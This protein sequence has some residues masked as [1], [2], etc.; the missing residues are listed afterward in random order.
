[1]QNIGNTVRIGRRATSENGTNGKR[2]VGALRM[3]GKYYRPKLVWVAIPRN[4]TGVLC[5]TLLRSLHTFITLWQ[6]IYIYIYISCI[7][8]KSIMQRDLYNSRQSHNLLHT[9]HN[10][11]LMGYKLCVHGELKIPS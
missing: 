5:I 4:R 8:V 6:M 11:Y 1:M 9:I 7:Y 10:H 2:D 3:R